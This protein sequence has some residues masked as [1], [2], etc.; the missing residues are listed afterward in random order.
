[1][2]PWV[3]ITPNNTPD[4]ANIVADVSIDN[5]TEDVVFNNASFLLYNFL[6][7]TYEFDKSIA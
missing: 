2:I 1:M 6:F 4:K 5:D 7:S 3:D